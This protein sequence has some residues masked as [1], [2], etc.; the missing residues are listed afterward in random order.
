VI[1]SRIMRWAGHMARM[2]DRRFGCRVLVGKHE[3]KKPLGR[4]RLRWENGIKMDLQEVGCG[5]MEWIE[6]T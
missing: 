6:M 2:E 1:I 4:P 3:G 5:S